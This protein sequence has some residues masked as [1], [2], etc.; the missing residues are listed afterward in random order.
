[1]DQNR[2]TLKET[3]SY[4]ESIE[5]DVLGCGCLLPI[6]RNIGGILQPSSIPRQ[7]EKPP[8]VVDRPMA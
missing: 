3:S 5:G 1:M 8:N 2:Y 6:E 4:E 7:F